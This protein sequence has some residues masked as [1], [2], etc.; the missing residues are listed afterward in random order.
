[1]NPAS[2]IG[3]HLSDRWKQF[4]RCVAPGIGIRLAAHQVVKTRRHLLVIAGAVLLVLL[5]VVVA[6]HFSAPKE[7]GVGELAVARGQII[8]YS[9]LDDSRGTHQYIIHLSGYR[10]AFQI[11]PDFAPYF[12]KT[13]FESELKKGD[14]LSV[15]IPVES[16]AKLIS[17]GPISVFA[18]R[19][20]TAT[21]LDEHN[22]LSAYN[23]QNNRNKQ[24]STPNSWVLPLIATASIIAIIGL[25]FVIRKIARVVSVRSRRP[26]SL[27]DPE[28]LCESSQ[29]L[30]QCVTRV[31]SEQ[32][33]LPPGRSEEKLLTAGDS[34]RE[35]LP[36]S[37]SEERSSEPPAETPHR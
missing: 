3:A 35:L 9:F 23:N 5:A 24:D 17:D 10:S 28:A 18:V 7:N 13:R 20:A 12:A 25:G 16:A 32:K 22:T 37:D 34:E 27:N 19:T 4:N 8:S 11:P 33:S 36:V 29:R 1:M 31:A 30:K 6:P 14:S 15:S 2:D 26:K 21:Y